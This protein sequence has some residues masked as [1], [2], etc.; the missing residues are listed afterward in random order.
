MMEGSDWKINAEIQFNE[1][2]IISFFDE[3]LIRNLNN[4]KHVRNH[5]VEENEIH[6]GPKKVSF[7]ANNTNYVLAHEII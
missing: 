7:A 2:A 6:D 4:T 5:I 1:K 3:D